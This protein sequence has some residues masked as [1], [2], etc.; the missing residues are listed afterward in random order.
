MRCAVVAGFECLVQTEWR[1][2]NVPPSLYREGSEGIMNTEE[3]FEEMPVLPEMEKDRLRGLDFLF[4]GITGAIVFLLLS[5]WAFPGLNVTVWDDVATAALIRPPE[6]VFPGF[7]NIVV[8]GIFKISG[9]NVGLGILPVLGR[10]SLACSV[11]CVYMLMVSSMALLAIKRPDNGKKYFMATRICAAFGALFFA[12]A[13]PVWHIGQTFSPESLLVFMTAA[14]LALFGCY[15]LTSKLACAYTA[16]IAAGFLSAETPLGFFILAGFVALY[17]VANRYGVVEE[18]L[19]SRQVAVKWFITFCFVSGL[20]AG[21]AVNCISFMSMD[22]LQALGKTSGNIPLLYVSHYW[23]LLSSAASVMGWTLSAGIVILPFVLTVFMVRRASDV[24]YFLPYHIG[25][26]FVVTGIISLTQLASLSPLWFWQWIKTPVMISSQYFLAVLSL[27]SAATLALA[28]LMFAMD[29]FCRNY[30]SIAYS[31]FGSDA[32][33][34]DLKKRT[35]SPAFRYVCFCAA[36]VLFV[37]AVVPGRRLPELRTM[38]GILNDYVEETLAECGD[39]RWIFTDGSFD[40]RLE[41]LS[42][43]RGK[44]LSALS[45]MSST[46]PREMY[47][48]TRG[49]TDKEDCF[50]LSKGVSAL[51]RTWVRDKPGRFKDFAVQ[52]GFEFWKRDGKE[53]PMSSG[54]LARPAGMSE[55][56]RAAGAERAKVLAARILEFYKAGGIPGSVGHELKELFLFAQWRISRIARMRAELM[57]REGKTDAAIEDVGLSKELDDNNESFRQILKGMEKVR[58]LSLKQMTPREG[59]QLALVRADFAMA[60]HYGEAIIEA[61]PE[62]ADA[63]FGIGMSYFVQG[64]FS[65]AETYLRRC[66][67]RNPN[68]PA[69]YNNLAII[70]L[71]MN[72]LDAA[73]RNAKKALSLIPKSAEVKDTLLQIQKAKKETE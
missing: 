43:A 27:L 39:I 46:S 8:R 50:A 1:G 19:V 57:D 28:L 52:L 5:V 35:R 31:Q 62:N 33:E 69:V 15:L 49:I 3:E 17:V 70:Q 11:F 29:V 32:D 71:K 54:V 44:S 68:E 18:Q 45:M 38:M 2:G 61:D 67:I 16:F 40:S 7:W 55:A 26:L 4:G 63:N 66:L 58:Q 10:L 72:R 64:Q 51:L 34:E 60:R 36:F 24:L 37:F 59:L 25:V 14:P 30:N 65:R 6:Y 22:G 21:I 23:D 73:E 9:L 47:I 13:D 48:H 56:D 42:A 12:C 20:V 41:V 53:I